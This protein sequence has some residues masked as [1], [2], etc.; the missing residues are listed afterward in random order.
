APFAKDLT[1]LSS[2]DDSALVLL[3]FRPSTE[4][5]WNAARIAASSPIVVPEASSMVW[6]SARS[7][8]RDVSSE[9]LEVDVDEVS[10]V[11][12]VADVVLAVLVVLETA[13]LILTAWCVRGWW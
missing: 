10:L 13:A 3:G 12:L 1:R 9:S 5:V 6:M 7:G 2:N 8:W 4:R 11:K